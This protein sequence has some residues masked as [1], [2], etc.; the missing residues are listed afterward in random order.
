MNLAKRNFQQVA[1]CHRLVIFHTYL[2]VIFVFTNLRVTV[3]V[4]WNFKSKQ[5]KS[6]CGLHLSSSW[7]ELIQTF[8]FGHLSDGHSLYGHL[9]YG[10]LSYGHPHMDIYHRRHM[11]LMT[12]TLITYWISYRR[13]ISF[14]CLFLVGISIDLLNHEQHLP[15]NACF[16]SGSSHMFNQQE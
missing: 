9:S 6:D 12:A 5:N 4:Y 16:D 13:K 10:H 7:Y 3:N 11:N 15:T 2:E 8:S 14:N 1:L